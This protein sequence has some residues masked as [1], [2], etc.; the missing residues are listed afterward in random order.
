MTRRTAGYLQNRVDPVRLARWFGAERARAYGRLV[1]LMIAIQAASLVV[2]LILSARHD[3]HWR[4]EPTDFD[5]FWSAAYLAV[6]GHAPWAYHM[7]PLLAAETLGAQPAAGQFLPYLYPPIFLMLCLPLALVPYQLAMPAFM[8]GGYAAVSAGFRRLLPPPWPWFAVLAFP[9]TMMN[10][11]MGQS[12]FIAALSFAAALGQLDQ[13]PALA[14]FYLGVLAYKPHLALCVPVALAAARR[15]TALATCGLTAFGLALLSY[16]VL[17]EQA[18]R[19]Y[20][21]ALPMTRDV[22]LAGDI[23]PKLLSSYGAVRILGGGATLALATQA[24]CTAL[25]LTCLIGGGA[26]RPGAG[27]E[28][29]ALAVAALVC[30]PYVLDYD[31]VCL[32]VPL[33]WLA[34][35][36]ARLGW[37]PWEKLLL[38][39][40]YLYPLEARNLNLAGLPAT[41][42]ILGALLS[43]VAGRGGIR[44]A[45][46]PVPPVFVAMRP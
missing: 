45:R 28:C 3:P 30:T 5:A 44:V 27:A 26:R 42:L 22:L 25:A 24:A 12:G 13:R 34:S 8:L 46:P 1:A 43:A 18:W 40:L 36:G 7:T 6:H 14:G 4:P 15:W 20:L 39:G 37:R 21:A 33:A 23:W 35:Q 32:G 41:P 11:T 31:L 9:A 29:S 19:A 17:G 2:R 16:A 38:V 10:A